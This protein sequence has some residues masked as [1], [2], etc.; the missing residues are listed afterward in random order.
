MSRPP[1]TVPRRLFVPTDQ[2]AF[3]NDDRPLPIRHAQTISAP[4][5][6]Q[7][8]LHALRQTLARI[9]RVPDECHVLDVGC[10]SGY[11]VALMCDELD[12]W[13]RTLDKPPAHVC[14]VGIEFVPE[15]VRFA[16]R[17]VQRWL[18]QRQNPLHP[19]ISWQCVRA[20]GW[21]GY[22]KRQ[23]YVFINVGAM[24]DKRPQMLVD[25]L[26]AGGR[27]LVPVNGDYVQLDK[28]GEGVLGGARV[29]TGVRFVPLKHVRSRVRTRRIRATRRNRM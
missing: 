19:C 23:P 21:R 9:T 28:V 7:M 8:T 14:V 27:L 11:V 26:R 20:N 5:I 12:Q 15:L 25:Q 18:A 24:A 6:H 22:A 2:R 17:N 4:H 13:V 1:L 3:A 16:R 10:G 29:L